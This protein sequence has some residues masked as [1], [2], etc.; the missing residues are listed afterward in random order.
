MHVVST[1]NKVKIGVLAIQG[2]FAEHIDMLARIGIHAREVRTIEDLND[3][4]GLIMP[5]GESTTIGKL[6]KFYGLDK[7]I[8]RRANLNASSRI[9]ASARLAP[10]L[11]KS[12]TIWGTCAG[13]ILLAKDVAEPRPDILGLMDIA[14]TRNAYGPQIESFETT[15]SI[16]KISKKPVGAVFIRAPKIT[17]VGKGVEILGS[18]SEQNGNKELASPV[19]VQYNN[20]LASTFHPELTDDTSVHEYFVSLTKHYAKK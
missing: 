13:A 15:V 9:L 5:G 7:E 19:M 11:P 3:V 18:H 4:D 17:R 10:S 6:M 12:L 8:K 16:P 1:Q 2:S 14:I 20:L